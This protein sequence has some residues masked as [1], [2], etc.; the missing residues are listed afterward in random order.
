MVR[1]AGRLRVL[2]LAGL[3]ALPAAAAFGALVIADRLGPFEALIGWAAAVALAVPLWHR[4]A[5]N[6]A[7]LKGFA[8]ALEEPTPPTPR[9]AQAPFAA[10]HAEV[11]RRVGRAL[12]AR[13]R[14][15]A[16]LKREGSGLLDALPD[17]LLVLGR[18]GRVQRLNRA[19]RALYGEGA[20]GSQ[21]TAVIRH[22]AL[23]AALD[24]VK[25]GGAR[26]VAFD[27][28]GPPPSA[29][30]AT[31][32]ALPGGDGGMAVAVRDR[33]A[34][35]LAEQMRADFVANASHEIRSPLA[36]IVGFIETLRGPA[37]D[38]AEA[39]ERFLAIMAE[40]AGRMTRLVDDL[41]SLSRIEMNERTPPQG[42]VDIGRA[43]G[44][45]KD[46]LAW[47]A[48]AK[49]MTI[50]LDV[51]PGLPEIQGEEAEIDQ[52]FHNLI[53]NSVKYGHAASR[54]TVTASHVRPE[55]GRWPAAGAVAVAVADVSD[56]IAREH[57]PRLTERFYRVD[58]G[59]SR[60]LGGTGLGLAI[61]KHVVNRHRGQLAIASTP[62]EGSVFTVVLPAA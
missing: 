28:A 13:E 18:D 54:I 5:G 20:L 57:I 34:V 23:L 27:E 41:L 58:A 19:A 31:V 60:Q 3:S 26:T 25:G 45:V 1:S 14:E 46:A 9:F 29:Y 40:Q 36:T 55:L 42:R 24:E 30:E 52:V 39:R 7:R 50:A 38:D 11:A 6:T 61:V 2:G 8:E 53:G 4:L 47:E 59:R 15:A 37:H 49:R 17:A 10:D 12:E 33:T 35:K 51:A 32:E 56:G 48:E 21:V 62:G 44:R 43:L 22:P 16:E